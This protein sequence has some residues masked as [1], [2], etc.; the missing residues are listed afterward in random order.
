MSTPA[1][2]WAK[3]S[4]DGPWSKYGGD[5]TSQTSTPTT[6]TPT[7]QPG[8]FSSLESSF[9]LIPENPDAE[10]QD[11]KEHP[12]R[13]A[14]N[15]MPELGLLRGAYEGA[16]HSLERTRNGNQAGIRG[17]SYRTALSWNLSHSH[18]RPCNG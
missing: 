12:I 15:A 14:I 11:V 16:K 3:Y 5:T 10:A 17:K 6:P 4:S 2:P 18:H 8:F 9:G 13:H 1:A 7:E